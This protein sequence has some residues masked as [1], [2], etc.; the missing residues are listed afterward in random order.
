MNHQLFGPKIPHKADEILPFY[1]DLPPFGESNFYPHNLRNSTWLI[2]SVVTCL[3]HVMHVIGQ[4]S[5]RY[6]AIRHQSAHW[7]TQNSGLFL[8]GKINAGQRIQNGLFS[9]HFS[10]FNIRWS[11]I[12]ITNSMEKHRKVI[13]E[14]I[15]IILDFFWTMTFMCN[16]NI[17]ISDPERCHTNVTLY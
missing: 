7:W 3:S 10:C 16:I 6:F 1:S 8:D 5:L 9:G 2:L 15:A 14:Y 11:I 12:T 4:A 17:Q 13:Q